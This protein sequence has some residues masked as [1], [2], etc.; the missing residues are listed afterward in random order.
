MTF[1]LV[2]MNS[3]HA[4][5]LALG[6]IVRM[7]HDGQ[8]QKPARNLKKMGETSRLSEFPQT[9]PGWPWITRS[10]SAGCGCLSLGW[11][12]NCLPRSDLPA[13]LSDALPS[14]TSGKHRKRNSKKMEET[15]GLSPDCPSKASAAALV[16]HD[17]LLQVGLQLWIDRQSAF[18]IAREERGLLL[19]PG[20]GICGPESFWVSE[21]Q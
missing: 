11:L 9:C 10:R 21:L 6:F 2:E 1:F 12:W 15:F 16:L 14:D 3:S 18:E 20:A 7:P 17:D 19:H 13:L 4:R 8:Q 5:S